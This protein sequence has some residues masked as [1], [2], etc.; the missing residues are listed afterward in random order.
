MLDPFDY[1]EP[2]CALCD[3]KEFYNPDK[4]DV[5][6]RIPVMRVIEKADSEFSKDNFAKAGSLL[7]Y[8]KD[9]A[10]CLNDKQG[11]LSITNELIGFYRKIQNK[12]K[13][14]ASISR[15]NELLQ[16]LNQGNTVTGATV[17][18]NCATAYKAF[19]EPEKSIPLFYQAES[20]YQDV[21]P[22]HDVRF[23]GLY[24]NMALTL[25]DLKEFK[26]AKDCYDKAILVMEKAKDGKPDLAITMVNMAHMYEQM[27]EDKSKIT[28]CM[29][30]AYNILNEEDV[31]H[32]GYYA[33]VLEK[34]APSFLH[35]GFSVIYNEFIKEAQSI[36]EGNR[37]C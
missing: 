4:S 18:L 33:Y 27:C 3:G 37:N 16:L 7:E 5:K 6:G 21:L 30:K 17:L 9:E 10:V 20:I 19:G 36:Y 2:K 14:Y 29:F 35:F 8:W 11:E 22:K 34:C 31:N 25:V 15:A 12:E 23:G 26:K 13:A 1:K 32:D 24:N 28:D